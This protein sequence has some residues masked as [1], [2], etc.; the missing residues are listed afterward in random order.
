M[1]FVEDIAE[2]FITFPDPVGRL[3]CPRQEVAA[4]AWLDR[5]TDLHRC[6][7]PGDGADPGGRGLYQAPAG[8][9]PA[10]RRLGVEP[11]LTVLFLTDGEPAERAERLF[12]Q[13]A[14]LADGLC[15]AGAP[16]AGYEPA[17]VERVLSEVG[18]NFRNFAVV[19]KREAAQR[20]ELSRASDVVAS[21]PELAE[22]VHDL[23][24]VIGLGR[25]IWSSR[26]S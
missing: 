3:R 6:K 9:A 15:A 7:H 1:E 21:V 5:R 16:L 22:D 8:Q 24:G 19:A 20:G 2:S 18:A 14:G 17:L 11:G 13:A 10:P 26:A 23:A 12:A 4:I 25:H